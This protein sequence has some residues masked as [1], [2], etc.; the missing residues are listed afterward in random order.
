[1]ACEI[2]LSKSAEKFLRKAAKGLA[3][4]INERLRELSENPTCKRNL[5]GP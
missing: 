5:R 1:M 2:K 4:R 3:D